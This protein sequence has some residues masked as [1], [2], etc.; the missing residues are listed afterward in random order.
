MYEIPTV[1]FLIGLILLIKGADWVV[2]FSSRIARTCGIS[3]FTIGLTLVAFSTSLPE[4]AV[5]LFSAVEGR[6]DIATGTVIG[7]NIANIG[8]IIGLSLLFRTLISERD[9]LRNAYLMLVVTVL[10]SLF[11]VDGLIWTE[12]IALLVL[13][14]YSLK[15]VDITDDGHVDG[16]F[17]RL[18]RDRSGETYTYGSSSIRL[19]VDVLLTFLGAAMVIIGADFVVDT[20]IEIASLFGIPEFVIAVIAIAVGTSLPELATSVTAAMKGLRGITIGNIIGSNIFNISI[21]GVVSL[22]RTVPATPT[23]F[24]I[25]V[26]FLVFFALV[27][28]FLLVKK[29]ELRWPAGVFLIAAYAVFVLLQLLTF[30]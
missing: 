13:L 3:E 22:M 1:L 16:L 9:Y 19:A 27:F 25:D 18:R 20:T 8:L 28:L 4:L 30:V 5:S 24:T 14:L 29:K 12:G 2:R 23:L 21:L 15:L 11:L 6:P 17:R 7:S 26:P 10:A